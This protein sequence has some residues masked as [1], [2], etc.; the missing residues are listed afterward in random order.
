MTARELPIQ[1]HARSVQGILTGRKGKTR[2][3]VK[4]KPRVPG[5][6]LSFPGLSLGFYNTAA[7]SKSGWVLRSRDGGGCWNDRTFPIHCPYGQPGDLLYVRESARLEY[8]EETDAYA[9][10]Y[11][12]DGAS[13]LLGSLDDVTLR[14]VESARWDRLDGD[15]YVTP[16][17]PGMLVPKH[18]SRLWLRRTDQARIERV[19]EISTEDILSEGVS[20]R[21]MVDAE[22][23]D[24]LRAEWRE[25]WE[26]TN[27]AG[28]WTR[29]DWVWVIAFQRT[30]PPDA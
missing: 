12:A 23:C 9:V 3:I 29:N 24:F 28:S 21:G 1:M 26:D 11:A 20:A 13:R 14:W 2:R 10:G 6:N 19:Q 22:A 27:G 5:L 18:C 30:E 8:D 16:L 25:L 7:G 4:W 15:V 17:R